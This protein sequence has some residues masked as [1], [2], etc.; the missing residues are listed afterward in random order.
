M[1]D[2]HIKFHEDPN[3]RWGEIRK[4]ILVFFNRWFS[5]YFSY[6]PNYAPPKPS[7]MDNFWILMN[8]FWSYI[9]KWT[10]LMNK[11]TPV[12]VYRLFSSLSMKQILNG[13]ILSKRLGM[14]LKFQ[15]KEIFLPACFRSLFLN[16]RFGPIHNTKFTLNCSFK[17]R[18]LILGM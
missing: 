3:F 13:K 5:M 15:W 14:K 8:F 10:F 9:S 18:R 1:I 4:T 2:H 16:I 11:R 6:F 7:D 12:S 17:G